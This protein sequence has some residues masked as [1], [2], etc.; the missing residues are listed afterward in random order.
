MNAGTGKF[1]EMTGSDAE[2][3]IEAVEKIGSMA[4]VEN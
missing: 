4:I 2:K 1:T 3:A